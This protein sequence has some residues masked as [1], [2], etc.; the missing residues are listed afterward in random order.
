[1]QHKEKIPPPQVKHDK[2]KAFD[3]DIMIPSFSIIV[4]G[5]SLLENATLK[6]VRGRK[7]GL[8]GRNGIGK[9][10]LI[11]AISRGEIEKFPMGVHILQVEQEIDGDDITVLQ[12]ILN[13]DVE[14]NELLEEMNDLVHL[15]DDE[16]T[17]EQTKQRVKRLA[18][19][20][21][22]LDV[23]E[24]SKAESKATQI[25]TGIGF[26]LED[27]HKPSKSFS[28][29]WRM[30]IAIAKVIFSEPEILLL[31]EPTNH[32]DLPALIWLENYIQTLYET[33]III[34]SHARDFL[35]ATCEEI[36]H[37]QSQ[38]LTYYKGNFE[39]FEKTKTE[40]ERN[41]KKA[42][43]SQLDKIS[44]IQKFIDKFRYN[45]KRASLVQSR[46][47]AI[48]R[49]DLVADVV[50]DPACVFMFPNPEK[51]SPPVCRLDEAKL[52]YYAKV[53]LSGVNINI[54]LETR[55]ALIGPNGAGK[56][57]LV[58]SLTGDLELIDGYRYLH[59]RLRIGMFTQH[60]MDLLD[61]RLS[62]VEQLSQRYP[63]E[64]AEK[65]RSHLGSFGI[66]GNL[67]LR[68]MYLLSGGQKSRVS[69]AMITW[70]K[71]HILLLDEPTNHLDFDA[72]NALIVALNNFEGGLVVVSHD[73]YFLSAVCDR[74]YI[75]N[76]QKVKVFEGGLADYRRMVTQ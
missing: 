29:G 48:Q 74:L 16:L 43:E 11:N 10:C 19:I 61:L 67:A 65:F 1:M 9:T 36:I 53:V 55:I 42:K 50:S 69:F 5:K 7:Y 35:N 30:R 39:Q 58:K 45:A 62:A 24:A 70:E 71:P 33:T 63:L 41:M 25:L 13:C 73:E 32:L 21:A 26:S 17:E 66:S 46:I 47:K 14:R 49:I 34:V 3:K 23:I 12:H 57:T 8:V 37:F 72:I 2:G 31:D 56:S 6:L 20:A 4:G 59:N 38:K 68:P 60:H 15:Q 28:G 51:L 64:Q 27:L 52:G 18:E 54:D 44:H 40:R 22:R 75:V 76:K